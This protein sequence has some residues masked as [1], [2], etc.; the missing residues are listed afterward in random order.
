MDRMLKSEK[1]W[2]RY[3]SCYPICIMSLI[4]TKNFCCASLLVTISTQFSIFYW[5]TKVKLE[6]YLKHQLLNPVLSYRKG[7]LTDGTTY[8]LV[9]YLKFSLKSHCTDLAS[10]VEFKVVGHTRDQINTPA[11][12]KLPRKASGRNN[13]AAC[14]KASP[15]H[16]G[17]ESRVPISLYCGCASTNPF[18]IISDRGFSVDGTAHHVGLLYTD[19]HNR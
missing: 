11:N 1:W 12:T 4:F 14:R 16:R 8:R 3:V 7:L 13:W 18:E 9:L 2:V 5:S 10:P 17:M 15:R 6:F 19:D